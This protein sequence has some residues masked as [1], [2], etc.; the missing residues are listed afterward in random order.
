MTTARNFVLGHFG[1]LNQYF[2]PGVVVTK[3][4]ALNLDILTIIFNRLM[5]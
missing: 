3:P 4:L 5:S 2:Y 1:K